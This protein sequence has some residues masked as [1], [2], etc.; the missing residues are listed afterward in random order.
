MLIVVDPRFNRSASVADVYATIRTGT[1]IVFIGGVIKYLLDNDKIQHD[2]VRNYT[3]LSFIVREDFDFSDGIFSGYDAQQRRY[4]RQSWDYER[5]E[6]GYVKSDPDLRHPRSVYQLLKQHYANHTPEMVQRVCGTPEDKFLQICELLASTS[7]PDRAGT[8]LYALGWT[9]HSIGSQMIRAGA[10]MQLLLGNIGIV[11]GGMNALRGHSNIQGLSDL[12]L[13]TDLLPGYLTLPRDEE[14]DYQAY[15][16]SRAPQPLRP[17]QMSYWQHYPKFHVSLMKA[18]YGDA[19]TAANNWAL[20]SRPKLDGM[21]AMRQVY[22]LM[23]RGKMTGYI[24]QG[25]N[26]LAAAPNKAKMNSA[27][28]KLKFLVVIDPLPTDTSEFWKNFGASNDV[29]PSQIQTEVF[30][31]PTTVFAEGEGAL[32]N[33]GRWLQWHWKGADAPK[34]VRSDIEIMS[35]LYHRLKR[36]YEEEGGAYPDPILNLSWQYVLDVPTPA[37]LAMEY[38]GKALVDLRSEERR[39]GKEWRE[40]RA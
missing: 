20:A 7:S 6:D 21:Y 2:Y 29:D 26:A 14:Q 13:M 34:G 10:M 30:R 35:R 17:N 12:G 31:L 24:C 3:D 4:D 8:I 5:D 22:E 39:V 40:Q 33:S 11:G 28:A 18:W 16:S 36:M 15:V 25:F 37:E 9:Q 19:A 32:V 23:D 27:L 38:N 1:D